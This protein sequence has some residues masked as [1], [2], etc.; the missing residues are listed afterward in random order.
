MQTLEKSPNLEH[1]A[2]C[3][4][5]VIPPPVLLLTH[6]HETT[7]QA[8]YASRPCKI[9]QYTSLT[10]FANTYHHLRFV[11]FL[12]RCIHPSPPTTKSRKSHINCD[13]ICVLCT[14]GTS[15]RN[16]TYLSIQGHYNNYDDWE[17]FST[18]LSFH[19][20]PQ[21]PFRSVERQGGC[22]TSQRY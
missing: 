6:T 1:R 14:P 19:H 18:R 8:R 10:A 16:R 2:N 12:Y 15:V 5:A 17:R 22:A 7:A 21:S 20:V 13:E 4:C 11:Y 9:A 3:L